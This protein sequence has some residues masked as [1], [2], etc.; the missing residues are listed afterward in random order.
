MI[1]EWGATLVAVLDHL[2]LTMNPTL[3]QLA[4]DEG[5][6]QILSG[7]VLTM[8]PDEMG[9]ASVINFGETQDYY[10]CLNKAKTSALYSL[11]Q[12]LAMLAMAKRRPSE[13]CPDYISTLG[14]ELPAS[15]LVN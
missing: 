7:I 15:P 12:L 1:E 9:Y 3:S 10:G 8:L 14:V 13:G 11:Q 5:L 2:E 6:L 4:R